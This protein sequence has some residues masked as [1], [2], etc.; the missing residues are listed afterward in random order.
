MKLTD[1]K[2]GMRVRIAA[3]HP[4]GYGGRTGSVLAV[5]TFEPLDQCGVLLDIGE[6][7]L[8]VIE[9][10]AL[11]EAPEEPLPPGWEEFEI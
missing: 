11:E 2:P 9:P 8:T 6:A 3:K 1:I 4:S 7:L 5:G 10:E